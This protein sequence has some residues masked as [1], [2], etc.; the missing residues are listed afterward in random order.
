LR[1]PERGRQPWL[2]TPSSSGGRTVKGA[3]K[4]RT[5]PYDLP[6]IS[7]THHLACRDQSLWPSWS[8]P[9]VP[10]RNGSMKLRLLMARAIPG[11]RPASASGVGRFFGRRLTLLRAELFKGPDATGHRHGCP[12]CPKQKGMKIPHWI[13]LMGR[14]GA[15]RSCLPVCPGNVAE[16]LRKH[17]RPDRMAGKKKEALR[18]LDLP[19]LRTGSTLF[20]RPGYFKGFRGFR[21][22]GGAL[23]PAVLA[24]PGDRRTSLPRTRIHG[25]PYTADMNGPA[26][27]GGRLGL[28]RSHKHAESV[29]PKNRVNGRH[30]P[31]LGN[32]D[33]IK[34]GAPHRSAGI[35]VAVFQDGRLPKRRPRSSSTWK[36]FAASECARS[37]L[38]L[39]LFATWW[40]GI[41]NR[42]PRACC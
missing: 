1:L 14:A 25:D 30:P 9:L 10:A 13:D 38:L 37:E 40:T 34:S 4:T 6:R 32:G 7:T 28:T 29:W 3:V 12:T 17:V 20:G 8:N 19:D 23:G 22:M 42:E 2:Y 21:A 11:L 5:E 33:V 36:K 41:G 26:S 24:I 35:E 18:A 31:G 16:K 39:C 27:R 15:K